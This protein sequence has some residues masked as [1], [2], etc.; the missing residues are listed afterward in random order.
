[1]LRILKNAIFLNLQ[2]SG[3]SA[4]E[5]M[6]SGKGGGINAV[7]SITITNSTVT[8]VCFAVPSL[9]LRKGSDGMSWAAQSFSRSGHTIVLQICSRTD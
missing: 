6:G 9:G 4:N 1:M 7:G 3:N 8:I 5:E 2:V